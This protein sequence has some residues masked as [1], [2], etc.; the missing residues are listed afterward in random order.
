ME[1]EWTREQ[2]VAAVKLSVIVHE[3]NQNQNQIEE[4]RKILFCILNAAPET[5]EMF[6]SPQDG[7]SFDM[8][9]NWSFSILRKNTEESSSSSSQ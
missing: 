4:R 5:R 7:D 8:S 1:A 3:M 9:S 2:V 6:K